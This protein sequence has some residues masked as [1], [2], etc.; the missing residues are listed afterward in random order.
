MNND[1]NL[2]RK[3]I[4][5]AKEEAARLEARVL[6]SEVVRDYTT[7]KGERI[8]VTKTRPDK[9]GYAVFQPEKD[10]PNYIIEGQVLLD[11]LEKTTAHNGVALRYPGAK[12]MLQR[13]MVG[14]FAEYIKD[15]GYESYYIS[16][17]MPANA[18]MRI[19]Q[20]ASGW[21]DE[22]AA[23]LLSVNFNDYARRTNTEF[24]GYAGM[25]QII[26][27]PETGEPTLRVGLMGLNPDGT[28]DY[29]T[30]LRV[31]KDAE[32]ASR[33]L[34]MPSMDESTLEEVLHVGMK[35]SQRIFGQMYEILG[36]PMMEG[37]EPCDL[38]NDAM[39]GKDI[40]GYLKN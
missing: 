24:G 30:M 9:Y 8:L 6:S 18:T 4:N 28:P 21:Y 38:L 11:D 33:F 5:A 36:I 29:K 31:C 37:V 19:T 22:D 35:N 2:E 10:E 7:E 13:N 14:L 1:V 40:S 20:Q 17:Q 23:I 15:P 34:G 32:A 27:H 25:A 26:P 16:V 3:I 39:S 12:S